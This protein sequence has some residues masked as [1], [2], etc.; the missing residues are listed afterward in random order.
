MALVSNSSINRLATLG[1]LAD[2]MAVPCTVHNMTLEK[3]IGVC[4]A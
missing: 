1:L 2:A 4:K 3:E